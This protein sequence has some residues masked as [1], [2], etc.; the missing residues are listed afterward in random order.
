MVTHVRY[1]VAVRS[2]GRVMLCAVCTVYEEMRIADFLVEPQN[3]G[4]RFDSGLASKPL[5][6]IVSGLASK[7][8]GQFSQVWPQNWWRRFLPVW[9]QNR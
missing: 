3:Q 4:R 8:V 1:S 6:R 5:G 2:R 9:P 7:P